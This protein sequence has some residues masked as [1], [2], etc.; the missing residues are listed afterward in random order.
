M[1]GISETVNTINSFIQRLNCYKCLTEVHCCYSIQCGH[2]V[3][4]HSKGFMLNYIINE[5][6]E[7]MTG[8]QLRSVSWELNLVLIFSLFVYH[9]FSLSLHFSLLLLDYAARHSFYFYYDKVQFLLTPADWQTDWVS[10]KC[11]RYSYFMLS[12]LSSCWRFFRLPFSQ[13]EYIMPRT[14]NDAYR[15]CGNSIVQFKCQRQNNY[16]FLWMKIQRKA[17]GVLCTLYLNWA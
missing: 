2:D 12:Q 9:F 14:E 1:L 5:Q 6:M 15:H 8:V 11:E 16:H 17:N 7:K 4:Q 3:V 10:V 13:R